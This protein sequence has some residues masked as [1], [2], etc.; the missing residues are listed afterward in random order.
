MQD[1][2]STNISAVLNSMSEGGSYYLRDKRDEQPYCVSKL[3]DGNLWMT[4]NLNIAGGTA[5]SSTDT[6]F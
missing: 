1:I 3:E 2:N 5:L 6:D 4:E